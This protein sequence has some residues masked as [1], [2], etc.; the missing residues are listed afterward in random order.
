MAARD[1]ILGPRTSAGYRAKIL[2]EIL[3]GLSGGVRILFR[4][5]VVGLLDHEVGMPADLAVAFPVA[6][7]E[8]VRSG[9]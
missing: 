3:R 8:S 9:N 2:L 7:E 1:N 5:V 4:D 6:G